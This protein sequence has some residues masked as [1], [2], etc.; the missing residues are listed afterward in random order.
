MSQYCPSCFSNTKQ[1]K[2]SGIV[3]V[4]IN[5]MQMDAGRILFN[6]KQ[7][8]E[9]ALKDLEGKIEEF[10]CWYSS[11]QN[12]QP[13]KKIKLY[14]NDFECL[15]GCNIGIKNFSIVD[16]LFTSNQIFRLLEKVSLKNPLRI[17]LKAEDIE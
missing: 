2:I 15:N 11:F 3:H 7:D 8:R 4:V 14:S 12:K 16:V 5:D 9:V 1:M 6:L 13:I 10:F 17:E